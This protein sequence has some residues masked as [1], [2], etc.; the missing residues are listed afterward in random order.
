MIGSKTSYAGYGYYPECQ[1][2]SREKFDNIL[3]VGDI[4]YIETLNDVYKDF[5]Q[6][7]YA[8]VKRRENDTSDWYSLQLIEEGKNNR[9]VY[10]YYHIGQ[11]KLITRKL[12]K[13][14]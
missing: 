11:L 6:E 3:R 5:P 9:T 4:V 7:Q 10:G 14:G 1:K 8:V 2:P 12:Y 13:N